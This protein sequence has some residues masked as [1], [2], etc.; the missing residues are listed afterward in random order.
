MPQGKFKCRPIY[1]AR[2]IMKCLCGRTLEFELDKDLKMKIQMHS[3]VCCNGAEDP[4]FAKQPGKDVTPKEA[5]HMI[6]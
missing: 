6:T 5:Q 1:F 2:G 3:K 4:G